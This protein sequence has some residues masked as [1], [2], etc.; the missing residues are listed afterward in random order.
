MRSGMTWPEASRKSQR[1]EPPPNRLRCASV[2][3]AT[4]VAGLPNWLT[5]KMCAFGAPLA[6]HIQRTGQRALELRSV[7]FI[8]TVAADIARP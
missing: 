6:E 5:T 8:R 3:A 7:R 2:S 4:Y 1:P